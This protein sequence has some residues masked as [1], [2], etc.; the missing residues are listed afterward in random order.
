MLGEVG[1]GANRHA[2]G[3]VTAVAV[4][5]PQSNT[6]ADDIDGQ[7]RRQQSHHRRIEGGNKRRGH[8]APVAFQ[9]PRVAPVGSA[10]TE[11]QPAPITSIG[12]RPTVAPSLRAFSVAARGS[13]TPQYANPG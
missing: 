10:M 1:T 8:D 11:S 5:N 12:W 13:C 2:H 7:D 3:R 4:I 6:V 9:R